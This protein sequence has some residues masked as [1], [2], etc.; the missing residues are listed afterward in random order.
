VKGRFEAHF[1]VKRNAIF[2]LRSKSN[3]RGQQ[4]GESVHNF[5]T[6]SYCLAEYCEFGALRDDL[7]RD[8]IML[9]V[10]DKKLSEQ[11]QLDPS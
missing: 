2:E 5:I 4:I 11:L 1:V 7:I 6:D 3:L 8:R 9:A 10:K